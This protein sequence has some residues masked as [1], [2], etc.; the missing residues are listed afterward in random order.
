M[1]TPAIWRTSTIITVPTADLNSLHLLW[2][3]SC[4][5]G[6]NTEGSGWNNALLTEW[7]CS[8]VSI[9]SMHLSFV[10][11]GSLPS[12]ELHAP[13]YSCL[14]AAGKSPIP[15]PQGGRYTGGAG[16]GPYGQP[17]IKQYK[18]AHYI[19]RKGEGFLLIKK[20]NLGP[21]NKSALGS[22]W[23]NI[24]GPGYL[25]GNSREGRRSRDGCCF[26]QQFLTC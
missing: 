19:P 8:G 4:Q 24:P 23:G 5:G 22:T 14:R 1:K 26:L 2:V 9:C 3:Q 12:S 20:N 13:L 16:Q 21:I 6:L 10:A 17:K 25:L 15:F 11:S 18:E 7:R